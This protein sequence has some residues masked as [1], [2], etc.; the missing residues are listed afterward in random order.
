M[1]QFPP[2]SQH[3]QHRQ[4]DLDWQGTHRGLRH[5]ERRGCSKGFPNLLFPASAPSHL[6]TS[7][8]R[9][10]RTVSPCVPAQAGL[11]TGEG[12][13][14]L[15][16]PRWSPDLSCQGPGLSG[17]GSGDQRPLGSGLPGV[18]TRQ[19]GAAAPQGGLGGPRGDPGAAARVPHG[20]Q[21]CLH[22][23]TKHVWSELVQE[24]GAGARAEPQP[25]K[26]YPNHSD[27]PLVLLFPPS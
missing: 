11:G 21:P 10:G 16:L 23:K 9:G 13:Q 18:D 7:P 15:S 24:A 2:A 5:R 22:S 26:Q 20:G 6:A 3:A 17:L 25:P 1:H 12:P 27:T 8:W 14:P 19:G 4:G